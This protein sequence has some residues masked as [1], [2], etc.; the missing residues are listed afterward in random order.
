MVDLS[1]LEAEI[2]HCLHNGQIDDK[3]TPRLHDLRR[4]IERKVEQ[5]KSKI[6]SMLKTNRQYCADGF[7][8]VRNGRYTMPVKKQYRNTIPGILVEMSNTGGTCF[9]EPSAVSKLQDELGMLQ[10]DEDYQ[11]KGIGRVMIVDG[12]EYAKKNGCESLITIPDEGGADI[13]YRKC[14]F[15]DVR[16]LYSLKIAT[17][18]YKNYEFEKTVV[19]KVPFSVIKEKKYIFGKGQV[20]SRHM[21]EVYNEKPST[22]DRID[23]AILLP[24]GTYI[25]IDCTYEGSLM[26]WSN[27]TNYS[28]IIKSALSFGYSLGLRHLSFNYLE[29]EE[30]FLDGFEVYDKEQEED[31]RRKR[32][33]FKIRMTCVNDINRIEN[34]RKKSN[35]QSERPHID[36]LLFV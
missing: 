29:D 3:A 26:I 25:Q 27:S 23:R 24:D 15:K 19:G 7:V 16:K 13:F 35:H 10:I 18:K 30:R 28:D 8:A 6:E 11:R 17:E 20:S 14:G 22:D 21:W 34:H 36:R 32:A 4:S 2:N 1:G 31:N 12:I 5:I 33:D 9:I